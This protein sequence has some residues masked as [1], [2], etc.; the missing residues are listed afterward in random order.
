MSELKE[1][2]RQNMPSR[3]QVCFTLERRDKKAVIAGEIVMCDG[4][5]DIIEKSGRLYLSPRELYQA[6]EDMNYLRPHRDEFSAALKM[7][8]GEKARQI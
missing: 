5:G 8:L 1:F 2:L 6:V 7:I 3:Y 4:A